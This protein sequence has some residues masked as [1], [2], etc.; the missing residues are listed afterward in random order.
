MRIHTMPCVPLVCWLILACSAGLAEPDETYSMHPCC[1]SFVTRTRTA[2]TVGEDR[3]A[4]SL[5]VREVDY[6]LKLGDDGNYHEL[7][8]RYQKLR[9]SVSLKYGWAQ[10]HHVG[11]SMPFMW[12]DIEA[13]G[14]DLRNEGLGNVAIFEKWNFLPESKYLPAI[15]VDAWYYLG[16][17]HTDRKLGSTHPFLKLTAEFSKTW[18]GFGLH[19][20]PVYALRDGPDCYQVNAAVLFTPCRTFWPAIE[21]NYESFRG[22]GRTHDIVPCCLWKFRRGWCAKLGTVINLESTKTYRDRIGLV[23]KLSCSF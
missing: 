9:T 3:L 18:P 6:D 21:Y 1:M 5:K 20:N 4:I 8:G 17:G 12:N 22:K 13:G 2:K 15:A 10:N 16:S 11:I 23:S 19:L 14:T 7:S